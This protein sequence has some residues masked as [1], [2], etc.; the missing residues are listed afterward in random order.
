M[1]YH[2]VKI[3]QHDLDNPL[4]L[5]PKL[6]LGH[7]NLTPY[8][9]MNVRLATQILSETTSQVLKHFYPAGTFGTSELCS[10]ANMFFDCLNARNQYECVKQL[11]ENCAP[12][13]VVND[14]R[15]TKL[16]NFL[17]YLYKWKQSV[18]DRTG[19]FTDTEREKMFLSHQT[20]KGILIT[21]KS[22]I[23]VVKYLIKD[24]KMPYVLTE[25]FNQDP[26]E[27][28]FGAQRMFGR[29]NNNPSAYQVGYNANAIRL[30]RST[31]KV[32]G[33]NTNDR[34]KKSKRS[35]SIVDD[36]TLEKRKPGDGLY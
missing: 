20:Y 32:E 30:L 23:E 35:W 27:A 12:Y 11:N 25:R 10:N 31:N 6:T 5:V 19:N 36:Q 17:S 33:G 22:T 34:N 7:I 1:W 13:R 18:K 15:F 26:L 24:A 3:V 2:F 4:K 14:N 16:E 28:Y 9:K 21:V 8:S 29:R